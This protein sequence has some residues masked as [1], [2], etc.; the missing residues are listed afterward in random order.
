MCRD[1][2]RKHPGGEKVLRLL[3]GADATSF[4]AGQERIIGVKHEHSKAAY[5]ILERYA[6]DHRIEKDQLIDG[7]VPVLWKV[8][9]LKSR[10][11]TWIHQPYEG[12][13]RLFGSNFLEG[14]TRTKWWVIPMVWMPLVAF[15][16]IS[17]LHSF[18]NALGKFFHSNW[19]PMKGSIL[20]GLLFF[21]GALAWT[22]LEYALHRGVFHWKPDPQSYNQITLHFLLH[23]LH[24][25]TPMDG[26]RLVFP[27]APALLIIAFFYA[28]YRSLLP[29]PVF[30]CFASGKL[31]GYICYDLSH[32]YLHH[33]TPTPHSSMHFRKVY[34]HNHHFKDYDQGFGISTVLWDHVFGTVGSGPL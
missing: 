30:C 2:P 11:W 9:N 1:S 13:L 7:D 21:V 31:F 23:G 27:P 8:G 24:H 22:L 20:A 14:L 4:M 26:D 29:D 28:I 12:S 16:A 18:V 6:V 15:F 34:H 17:G 5:D 3:A 25:K 19:S 32:Y 33:G 10:Y